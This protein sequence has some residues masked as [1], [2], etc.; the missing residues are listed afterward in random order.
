ML[1]AFALVAFLRGPLACAGLVY[2]NDFDGNVQTAAGT[3]V[4]ISG[5]TGSAGGVMGGITDSQGYDAYNHFGGDFWR[6]AAPNDVLEFD[7][8]GLPSHTSV[9]VCF[10]LGMMDS[11]DGTSGTYGTDIINVGIYDGATQIAGISEPYFGAT[12]PST[13]VDT[14]VVQNQQL[15]FN[16]GTDPWWN[17]DGYRMCFN[18]LTHS[19]GNLTVRFWGSS[20]GTGVGFQGGNDESFAID[21]L[22]ITAMPEPTSLVYLLPTA[23]MLLLRRKRRPLLSGSDLD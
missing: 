1:V 14:I 19:S 16:N 6:V 13:G 4:A 18:N 15:G 3:A 9:S 10:S 22:M 12:A 5:G 8:T 21:E 11:W 2:S 23:V 20:G 17:D 7:L